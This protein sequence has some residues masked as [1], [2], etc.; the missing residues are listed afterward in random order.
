[1]ND[2]EYSTTT[3]YELQKIR[4]R[5]ARQRE[6]FR[7]A[8]G[9]NSPE[10]ERPKKRFDYSYQPCYADPAAKTVPEKREAGSS[11]AVIALIL[12]IVSITFFWMMIFVMPV[13]LIGIIVSVNVIRKGKDRGLGIAGLTTSCIGMLF[14]LGLT[15]FVMNN[16]EAIL[17]SLDKIEDQIIEEYGEDFYEP[18]IKGPKGMTFSED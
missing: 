11:L 8:H 10:P 15:I 4:E 2:R 3:E 13:A 5:A 14:A 9:E 18:P 7:R 12:G 1:M 17:D 6:A 16:S